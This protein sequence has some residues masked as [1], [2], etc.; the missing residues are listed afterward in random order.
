MS[1]L[2]VLAIPALAACFLFAQEAPQTGGGGASTGG[3]TGG[4]ATTGGG[5]G[6]V[7]G[8]GA[9]IPGGGNT[10]PGTGRGTTLPGQQQEDPFGRNRFPDMGPRPIFLSGKVMMDD[11]GPPP[12]PVTIERLCSGGNPQTEGY[13]DSKGSFSFEL[14]RNNR[15]FADASNGGNDDFGGFPTPGAGASSRSGMG[16][17]GGGMSGGRQI[18]ERDLMGCEIRAALPGYRSEPVQLAGRRSLD[19]PNIGTIILRRLA[20][21]EGLTTSATSLMAPKEARK[22]YDKGREL[23]K[24]K[25][26]EEARKE[27]EKALG[28]YPKYAVAWY[29]LGL[30]HETTQRDQEAQEAYAKAVEADPKFIKPYITIAAAQVREQK[31]KEAAETSDKAIKLNPY[32]FPGVYLYSSLAHLNLKELDEAEKSAR[33][34]LKSDKATR[35]PKLA[36]IL[37]IVLAQK[38]DFAG[39]TAN[40]KLYLKSVMPGSKDAEFVQKQIDQ[41]EGLLAQKG[42]QDQ[43]PPQQQQ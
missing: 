13:T 10:G 26:P 28:L 7:G 12:E 27:Y 31:W 4:G 8:G 20:N 25:K 33:D 42:T 15:M 37:G 40:L 14:G 9:A 24:K 5:V 11:G 39:A 17:L 41:V 43:P 38:Q 34:G 1:I 19:N 30:V 16:N 18:T 36:H 32:D 6:G 21:V 35:L 29:E 3:G 22:S 2:R 23:M